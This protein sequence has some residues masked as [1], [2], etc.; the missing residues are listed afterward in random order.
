MAESAFDVQQ[1]SNLEIGQFI[2]YCKCSDLSVDFVVTGHDCQPIAF[3]AALYQQNQLIE[4]SGEGFVKHWHSCK[5]MPGIYQL[6]LTLDP[7]TTL[8]DSLQWQEPLC[9][10]LNLEGN[11]TTIVKAR[12]PEFQL[13]DIPRIMRA[14][15]WEIG[16]KLMERWF[17]SSKYTY[18]DIDYTNDPT[19]PYNDQIVTLDW[20]LKYPRAKSVYDAMWTDKI[21]VNEAAKKEIVDAL[22]VNKLLTKSKETFGN[23]G[24]PMDDINRDG[25]FYIQERP[26]GSSFHSITNDLDG[27][28]AALANF[29]FRMAVEGEVIYKGRQNNLFGLFEDELYEIR[30]K[31]VGIYVRDSYDFIGDQF[32]GLGYWNP[33]DNKVSKISGDNFHEVTN[34]SFRKWREKHNKGGDFTVYSNMEIREVNESWTIEVE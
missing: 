19:R 31:R 15:D 6:I 14:N 12:T 25:H 1:V 7:Q 21:Y 10:E 9:K 29:T 26:V 22:K 18:P 27:M 17:T 34:A 8:T 33:V 28:H 16:A 13:T 5:V 2:Q 23:L 3:N 30:I 24:E 4:S 32:G 20:A 11:R